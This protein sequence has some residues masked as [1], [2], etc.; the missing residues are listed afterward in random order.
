MMFSRNKKGSELT[1]TLWIGLFLGLVVLFLLTPSIGKAFTNFVKSQFKPESAGGTCR[2]ACIENEEYPNYNV[3]CKDKA[4]VYCVRFTTQNPDSLK[5]KT[6]GDLGC[7]GA[8][9]ICNEYLQCTSLCEYCGT[10]PLED[11]CTIDKINAIRDPKFKIVIWGDQITSLNNKFTCGCSM[12][13]CNSI[14]DG[15]QSGTCVT[16]LCNGE[17][18][19]TEGSRCCFTT[20]SMGNASS[21]AQT[22]TTSDPCVDSCMAATTNNCNK[23][24]QD[25]SV[26]K[27]EYPVCVESTRP[28]CTN[29]CLQ[30]TAAPIPPKTSQTIQKCIDECTTGYKKSCYDEALLGWIQDSDF[31]V[32]AAKASS[33]CTTICNKS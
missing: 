17:D 28:L 1:I 22:A 21:T 29:S 3:E 10:H 23:L 33:S 18:P 31:P 26:Q 30:K 11:A 12:N 25:G 24:V 2:L 9:T 7:G 8:N 15:K 16:N 6:K 5:C 4:N 14:R 19:T 27:T 20:G 13:V 32:C